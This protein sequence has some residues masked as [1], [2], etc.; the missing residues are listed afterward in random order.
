MVSVAAGKIRRVFVQAD[1]A[2]LTHLG[3][4]ATATS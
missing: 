1:P 4:I 3:R 2:R